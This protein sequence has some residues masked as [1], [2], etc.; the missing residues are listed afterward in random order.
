MIDI[1]ICTF[2]RLDRQI[3]LNSIPESYRDNVTLVVQPQEKEEAL[4]VHKNIFVLDGDNIGYAKTIKQ[5][6][7]EWAVNRKKHF[8]MLDDDLTFHHNVENLNKE[9]TGSG[10][11]YP[12]DEDNFYKL[13]E[14]INQDLSNGLMHSALGTTWV[15]PW[16]KCPYIENSRICGNKVYNKKLGE[17]WS[18]ID[19]DGC[20]GA[21]DFYVNL[22]LL[23]KG[24]SNKVWYNYVISPGTSYAEG[25]CSDYRTLEYHNQSCRDLHEKFPQFVRLKENK[26]KSGPWKGIPKLGAYVQ[27]KKAYRS[28]QTNTLEEFI[29][30][31]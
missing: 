8:W 18:E 2:K 30:G 22:Q 6:T 5:A 4:K 24:Y 16:G 3:T 10:K 23:T 12:L 17:I 25:G 20:C 14:L 1:V 27:W 29:N 15:I 28:S 26:I 13:L 11:K 19:W 21:E 9:N 31:K 7:Y